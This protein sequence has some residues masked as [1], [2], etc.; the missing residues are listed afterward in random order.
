MSETEKAVATVKLPASTQ[1][2]S[3]FDSAA[4]FDLAQ[5]MARA[6][7]TSDMVPATYRGEDKIGNAIIALDMAKR[8]DSNPVMVMQNLHIIEGRPSWSSQFIIAALNSCGMFS[9]LRFQMGDEGE[10]EVSYQTWGEQKG[11]RVTKTQK[12]RNLT[13]TAY[14]I[15]KA[16]G[17]RLDGPTV[18]ME[19]S[20]AEGWYAK[21]GSKW[22]TMP[23]LMLRYRA[24]AFFGRLYAPQILMG[25]QTDDEVRDTSEMR[26]VSPIPEVATART[27]TDTAANSADSKTSKVTESKADEKPAPAVAQ[28]GRGRPTKADTDAAEADGQKAKRSG[29][30]REA[31]PDAFG[32]PSLK[33]A[34]ESG[35]DAEEARPAATDKSGAP[36]DF[37]G[38]TGEVKENDAAGDGAAA[39]NVAADD[40]GLG[41]GD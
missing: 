28:A 2:L 32:K 41:F 13:C 29:V 26:D 6:L 40:D 3:V 27:A 33:A 22:Q 16:T 38:E 8:T 12:I 36:F 31:V 5:R 14:A 15:E 9:P 4:G 21:N 37:D 7:V 17:E 39:G 34:W 24:A 30:P 25:M 23:D 20:V 19:M 1:A 35:W 10:Q 11:Q 18:S